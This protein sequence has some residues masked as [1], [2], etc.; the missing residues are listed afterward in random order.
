MVAMA[1]GYES[2]FKKMEASVW[3]FQ[4]VRGDWG[5]LL[6]E[7]TVFPGQTQSTESPCIFIHLLHWK[8]VGPFIATV[9]KQQI[10]DSLTFYASILLINTLLSKH[11][12][13]HTYRSLSTL[14]NDL[15]D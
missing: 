11:I 4:L 1:S 12:F 7:Q 8:T 6:P 9:L 14:L 13:M 15:T 10:F 3:S 5:V 2:F